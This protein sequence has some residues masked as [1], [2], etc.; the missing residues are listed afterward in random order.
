MLPPQTTSA[1]D[2]DSGDLP[3]SILGAEIEIT[4]FVQAIPGQALTK[5]YRLDENGALQSTTAGTISNSY[6][7]RV[8]VVSGAAQLADIINSI[9]PDQALAMGRMISSTTVAFFVSGV[10]ALRR[11]DELVARATKQ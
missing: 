10:S 9:A 11:L 2:T 4:K 1:P 5:S 6:A 8:L 3:L 7:G